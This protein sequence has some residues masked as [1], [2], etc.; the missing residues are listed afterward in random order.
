[1]S[2]RINLPVNTNTETQNN[3]KSMKVVLTSDIIGTTFNQTSRR[4]D[5]TMNLFGL[6]QERIV[7]IFCTDGA[8]TPS[9]IAVMAL[10]NGA[11]YVAASQPCTL[12][13]DKIELRILYK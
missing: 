3:V 12:L 11:V 7:G 6:S 2:V 9:S 5:T 1:M 8:L 13:Y 4:I 10:F